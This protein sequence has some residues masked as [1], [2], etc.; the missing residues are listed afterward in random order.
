[1][2]SMMSFSFP[3]LALILFYSSLWICSGGERAQRLSPPRDEAA[4]ATDFGGSD[5]RS[6]R[7]FLDAVVRPDDD[8]TMSATSHRTNRDRR[9]KREKRKMR[10]LGSIGFLGRPPRICAVGFTL[11][12]ANKIPVKNGTC[13]KSCA[14]IENKGRC[15]WNGEGICKV[16][17]PSQRRR[18]RA[19]GSAPKY[20]NCPWVPARCK[21][22]A[23]PNCYKATHQSLCRCVVFPK[24]KCVEGW[25][26]SCT[27]TP[28]GR[29]W[30][31]KCLK[32][33][34]GTNPPSEFP[35]LAPSGVNFNFSEALL[36][37]RTNGDD[38]DYGP[39]ADWPVGRVDDMVSSFD[40]FTHVDWKAFNVDIGTWDTSNVL[41]MRYMFRGAEVFN[42]DIGMWD[43]SSLTDMQDM[44]TSAAVFNQ[45]IGNWDVSNV[46]NFFFHL[47][48]FRI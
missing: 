34:V 8:L 17:P 12:C 24:T 13:K 10:R 31:C 26:R 2:S 3:L 39:I 40:G 36:D 46:V 37:Y 18:N 41:K 44:F 47:W 33:P 5:E 45:R 29:Y 27:K 11:Q 15:K 21:Y 4:T 30:N 48:T 20:C 28:N 43:T 25:Y 6:P 35:S 23:K 7:H 22:A 42:Q 9:A 19:L 38:N 14:C 16:C 1:M 32:I